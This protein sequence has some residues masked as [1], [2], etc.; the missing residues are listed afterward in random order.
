MTFTAVQCIII[1]LSFKLQFC[2]IFNLG[3]D[4]YCS[5]TSHGNVFQGEVEIAEY[6]WFYEEGV[7]VQDTAMVTALQDGP[8][9]NYF[10]VENDFYAYR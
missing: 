7:S 4:R 9:V 8:I 1:T 10:R 5:Y 2:T 6:K 3:T